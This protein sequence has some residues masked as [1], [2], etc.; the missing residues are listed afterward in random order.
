MNGPGM[1]GVNGGGS[2]VDGPGMGGVSGGGS[3]VDGPGSGVMPGGHV[4][5]IPQGLPSIIL[6]I[7]IREF[8]SPSVK[9]KLVKQRSH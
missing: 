8:P 5:S 9:D 2:S 6:S 3:S 1:G 7:A 4:T